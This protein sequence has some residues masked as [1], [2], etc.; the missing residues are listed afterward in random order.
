MR[1][2]RTSGESTLLAGEKSICCIR[3]SALTRETWGGETLFST[4]STVCRQLQSSLGVD[5]VLILT[6]YFSLW[7]AT[8]E[9]AGAAAN[10]DI[11]ADDIVAQCERDP[12][13]LL[14]MYKN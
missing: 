8:S 7:Q 12:V 13:H 5:T 14:Q 10:Y 11:A 9:H 6:H 1:I 2:I 3:R 4:R